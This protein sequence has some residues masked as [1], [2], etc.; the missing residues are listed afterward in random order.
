MM[1]KQLVVTIEE[2][3]IPQWKAEAKSQGISLSNLIEKRMGVSKRKPKRFSDF[4]KG[5]P[6]LQPDKSPQQIKE[7]YLLEKYG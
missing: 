4:F 2:S 5:K 6:D 7:E 1:K 3:L